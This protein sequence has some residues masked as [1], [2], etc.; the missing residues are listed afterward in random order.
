L[1]IENL[2][3]YNK[4]DEKGEKYEGVRLFFMYV[5]QIGSCL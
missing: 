1:Q 5:V 4:D 2:N 3:R